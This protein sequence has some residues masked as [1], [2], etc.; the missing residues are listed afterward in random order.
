MA[1]VRSDSTDQ[2]PGFSGASIRVSFNTTS[3]HYSLNDHIKSSHCTRSSPVHTTMG[4]KRKRSTPSLSGGSPESY[5]S[6]STQ[7]TSPLSSIYTQTKPTEPFFQKP[8]WS[9]PTYESDA[10]MSSHFHLGSRTRKRHRDDRPDESEVYGTAHAYVYAV[11]G[12]ANAG[13]RIPSPNSSLLNENTPTPN[14]SYPLSSR[15][16]QPPRLHHHNVAH[17]IP[18]GTSAASL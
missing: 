8:T 7:S 6:T 12:Y 5:T 14:Q 10:S 2:D 4:L 18:S 13:Q 11:F 17:F 1:Q 3:R 16:L 15:P 9:F